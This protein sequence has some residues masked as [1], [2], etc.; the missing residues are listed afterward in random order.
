MFWKHVDDLPQQFSCSLAE[1]P[2]GPLVETLPDQLCRHI[3][4]LPASETL[5]VW[6]RPSVVLRQERDGGGR[7]GGRYQE[8][9]LHQQF[10]MQQ[11]YTRR[12]MCS[13]IMV[14][15]LLVAYTRFRSCNSKLGTRLICT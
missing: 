11:I 9:T 15:G 3:T 2:P 10:K 14:Q 8:A 6:L 1:H 13:Q 12:S 5:S 7:G 4:P